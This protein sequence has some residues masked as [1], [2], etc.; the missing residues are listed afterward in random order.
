M[1]DGRNAEVPPGKPGK[2]ELFL[3]EEEEAVEIDTEQHALAKS[4]TAKYVLV[5]GWI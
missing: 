2:G 5:A 3:S 1:F 4:L